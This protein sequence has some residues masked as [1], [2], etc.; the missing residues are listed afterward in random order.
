MTPLVLNRFLAMGVGSLPHT[1][2]KDACRLI[3]KHLKQDVPFWPQLPKRNFKENM[4][5]QFSQMLPGV[6]IDEAGQKI[7]IDASGNDYSQGLEA[8][9]EHYL[10]EDL[11]Y[12]ALSKDYAQGFYE[13]LDCLKAEPACPYIK[14]QII[15]PV[16]FGLTVCAQDKKASIYNLEFR[17]CLVKALEMKARWQ[18][19]EMKSISP[20]S[21]VIICIDEPYLVSIGSSF[22]NINNEEVAAMLNDVVKAIHKEG[23]YAAVHCCGNTDWGIVLK[24][25]ID[26]LNFDACN[27]LE[28]IFIYRKELEDFLKRKGILAFGIIPNSAQGQLPEPRALLDKIGRQDNF[29][30]VSPSCG[31]S[32][33]SEERADE[34]LGLT[35]NFSRFLDGIK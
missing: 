21:R 9:Y 27:Y 19:R 11:D 20:S 8:L 2:P 30:L 14:G 13:F 15:G 32:G 31:L 16:S 18:V 4:Y 35:S 22:F 6:V 17:D 25:G 7:W 28:T 33:V 1:N 34:V 10:T 23:A 29:C 3:F 26:I 24:T 5:V 12:F